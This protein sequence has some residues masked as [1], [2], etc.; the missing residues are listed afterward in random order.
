MSIFLPFHTRAHEITKVL[1][2]VAITTFRISSRRKAACALSHKPVSHLLAGF[3]A[4]TTVTFS[5]FT[6]SCD[7]VAEH[8]YDEFLQ[9][10][11]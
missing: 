2:K 4:S 8:R 5:Y 3:V 6:M 11:L 7:A 9:I 10:G 1:L